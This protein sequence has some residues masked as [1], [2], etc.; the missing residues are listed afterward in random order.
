M[1]ENLNIKYVLR[2]VLINRCRMYF[3]RRGTERVGL[4]GLRIEGFGARNGHG[5]S[6]AALSRGKDTI[7][8]SGTKKKGNA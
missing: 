3:D 8:P 5:P 4:S 7:R 1:F 2:V 6:V